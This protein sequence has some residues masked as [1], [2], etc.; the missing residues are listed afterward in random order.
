MSIYVGEDGY[1]YYS[2]FEAEFKLLDIERSCG[3]LVSLGLLRHDI[4][5]S[6]EVGGGNEILISMLTMT[7][8]GG[9]FFQACEGVNLP[10]HDE[11]N[12]ER[13]IKS[14]RNSTK[15]EKQK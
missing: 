10:R 12:K 3:V 13:D 8:F 7:E 15:S 11:K 2:P 5:P 1:D 6:I 14:K 4:I 9:Q